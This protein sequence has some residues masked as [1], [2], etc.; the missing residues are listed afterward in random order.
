[1]KKQFIKKSFVL[2]LAS[3]IAVGCSKND[4]LPDNGGEETPKEVGQY[5]VAVQAKGTGESANTY[6]IPTESLENPE[7][8]ISPVG[9]GL[10]INNT[11]SNY[12]SNAYEG[13]VTLKYGQG[14]AH[15]GTRVTINSTGKA[16][17][18]GQQFEIQDGFV[19]AGIVGDAVYT[20]MSGFR[21]KDKTKATFN[22]IPMSS[23]TPKYALMSVDK[24]TGY[25]GKNA[26][27][28]GIADAG[29]GSFYTGLDYSA[30]EV[31]ELVIAKIKANS[32]TPEAVYRDMR[33]SKSGG[34]YRSARYSQIGETSKGDVYVFSGNY[35]GTKTAGALLLKKGSTGFDKDYFWDIEKA[36]E[37][38]RFRKVWYV[39]DDIFL[40]EFY[41]DKSEVGK[42]VSGVASQFAVLN[43]S[44]KKFTWI[45]G[46]PA[47]SAIPDLGTGEPY[48]LDG[49]VY[50]GIT[51]TTEDPRFYVIDPVSGVAKKGLLVKN[52]ESIEAA[53]FV[54]Q[55]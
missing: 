25:E 27:L 6:F 39:Q 31:D 45:T 51:T 35:A 2:V 41:N 33:L 8:S 55:K 50:L 12:I 13:F 20:A 28:V 19:T 29:N 23:S 32:L 18:V 5:L 7:A 14:N 54:K 47:K 43:M 38:Y 17:E 48:V 34:Q 16:V 11:F 30:D 24:F 36:S 52:A 37:G 15:V 46:L 3:M 1:M 49:K 40:L 9:T 10:E 44:S 21:A 22:V 26:A 53:T 4:T 42:S